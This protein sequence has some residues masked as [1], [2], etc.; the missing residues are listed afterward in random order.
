M[1]ADF[2]LTV[3][4]RDRV[5]IVAGLT[6]AIVELGGNID[7]ISQTVMKG[8]FTIIVTVQF[9]NGVTADEL[10][11]AVRHSGASGELEVSVKERRGAK[12]A[13]V[14]AGADRFILTIS[15]PDRPGIIHRITS[16]LASRGINI[17]DLYAYSEAEGFIL[18]AQLEVP[19]GPEVERLQMDVE[20]LWPA[21]RMQVTLQHENIFLATNHVDFRQDL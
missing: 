18:M 3:M 6:E 16:Y 21:G 20:G 17:E 8:Y 9:A 13:P 14:P 11:S 1:P 15:G 12:T 7:A 5:G 2:V 19:P 10:A 4:S